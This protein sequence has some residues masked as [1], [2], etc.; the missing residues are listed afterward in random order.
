MI[1]YFLEIKNNIDEIIKDLLKNND[2]KEKE[3]KNKNEINIELENEKKNE[4]I[5]FHLEDCFLNK[6]KNFAKKVN[7]E[8]KIDRNM[9]KTAGETPGEFESNND[10][11]KIEPSNESYISSNSDEKESSILKDED[12]KIKNEIDNSLNE[13]FQKNTIQDAYFNQ[14][15][16]DDQVFNLLKKHIKNDLLNYIYSK[17]DFIN[18]YSYKTMTFD[19]NIISKIISSREAVKIFKGK[20]QNEFKIIGNNIDTLKIK[21]LSIIIIGK[22]G[23]GKSTLINCMLKEYL[24][25]EGVGDRITIKN[26]SYQNAKIPFL[27]LIDTRGIELKQKYGPNAIL[28]NAIDYIMNQKNKENQDYNKYINCIWF[29]VK[30]DDIEEKEIEIIN[31]LQQKESNLPIIV[32]NTLK[33]VK[34][35]DNQIK[36]KIFEKCTNIKFTQILAKSSSDNE[37]LSYGL[38]DLLNITLDVCKNVSKGETFNK[39]KEE[40]SKIIKNNFIEQNNNIKKNIE[41]EIMP[42]FLNYDKYLRKDNYQN[43]IL[44]YLEKVILEFL[45]LNKEENNKFSFEDNNELNNFKN[46]I[47]NIKQYI[48]FYERETN[49]FINSL[50]NDKIIEYL[51]FQVGIEKKQENNIKRENK[52]TK[53]DFNDIISIFLNNNFNFIAQ[54][55]YLHCIKKDIS[56]SFTNYI[57]EEIIKNVEVLLK[58]D[59]EDLFKSIYKKKF[60]DF[61]NWIN[62]NYRKNNNNIYNSLIN[63]SV[64]QGN[65]NRSNNKKGG[66]NSSLNKISERSGKT[67][68]KN[69]PR[70]KTAGINPSLKTLTGNYNDK[71][72][73]NNTSLS[74]ISKKQE[75]TSKNRISIIGTPE[76]NIKDSINYIKNS[77]N[78]IN[79]AIKSEERDSDILSDREIAPPPNV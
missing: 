59:S 12:L 57:G 55:H 30:G 31:N 2:E 32:V 72:S 17:K 37:F 5:Q 61:N 8:L 29:C 24:A 36:Q 28:D 40:I 13:F 35:E 34:K 67:S 1:E 25:K 45:K 42:R 20:I 65:T 68:N 75:N 4:E 70:I 21:Y 76:E 56:E 47:A 74:N 44:K 79:P 43:Y 3:K 7:I 78:T 53:K 62:N 19:K 51:D 18:N 48:E 16:Q 23:V 22:S 58:D 50:L 60:S 14:E 64:N 49:K 15:T 38:D 63:T 6:L 10:I 77:G 71:K 26:T 46:V 33:Y 9:T 11:K 27:R 73:E 39:M 52:N 69:I 66:I 54:K 41:K